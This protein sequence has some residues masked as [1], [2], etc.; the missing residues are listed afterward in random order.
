MKSYDNI[1][2]LRAVV[3]VVIAAMILV[4]AAAAD[5]ARYT[6]SQEEY[7]EPIEETAE[8]GAAGEEKTDEEAAGKPAEEEVSAVPIAGAAKEQEKKIWLPTG[9]IVR[10]FG[11]QEEDGIWR[12]HTGIDIRIDGGKAVYAASGGKVERIERIAGGYLIEV[13]SAG[14]LWRYEPLSEVSVAVG[15]QVDAGDELGRVPSDKGELHIGCLR[16]GEWTDPRTVRS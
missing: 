16:A 6:A 9:E 4:C 1:W 5:D 12:Y 7:I 2:K 11:W 8:S 15:E 14:E 10:D 3:S 13:A